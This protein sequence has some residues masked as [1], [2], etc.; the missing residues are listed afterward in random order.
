MQE[1]VEKS[2]T[3]HPTASLTMAALKRQAERKREE[4]GRWTD[5]GRAM[6]K[7]TLCKRGKE[8]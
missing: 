6:R 8:K 5:R 4:I 7:K 2:G 1:G 3:V